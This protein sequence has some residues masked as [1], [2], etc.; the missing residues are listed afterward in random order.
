VAVG[1]SRRTLS[2]RKTP[3]VGYID[4]EP[5]LAAMEGLLIGLR[6]LG[7]VE[8][9]NIRLVKQLFAGSDVFFGQTKEAI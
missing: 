6:E 8:G 3:E 4:G 1:R 5:G 2:R 7:Y 9:Q